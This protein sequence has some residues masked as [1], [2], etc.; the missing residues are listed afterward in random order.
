MLDHLKA[1]GLRVE[2]KL[3]LHLGAIDSPVPLDQGIH[4]VLWA[5]VGFVA[6]RLAA[7]RF[8]PVFI[9]PIVLLASYL[10]ELGQ[11]V[12]TA[13]R[14]VEASDAVAN[15]VGVG[16]GILAAQVLDWATRRRTQTER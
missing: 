12:F 6:H 13:G 3:G 7:R 10:F 2:R 1:L 5:T 16:V 4:V 9:A 11:A 14:S 15:A 8:P